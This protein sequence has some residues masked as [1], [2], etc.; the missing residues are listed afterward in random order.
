M[1]QVVLPPYAQCE[2]L[3]SPAA[4][5]RARRLCSITEDTHGKIAGESLTRELAQEL[6]QGR[7]LV[8]GLVSCLNAAPRSRPNDARALRCS[9][10]PS[11]KPYLL[12]KASEARVNRRWRR[13]YLIVL[14]LP[15]IFTLAC[16][17]LSSI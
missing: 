3:P 10:L 14:L 15:N 11:S 5:N 7:E 1:S 16:L 12:R 4:A 2:P 13:Y 17:S 8:Q 9:K 6:A